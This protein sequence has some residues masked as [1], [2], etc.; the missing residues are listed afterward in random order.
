MSRRDRLAE[1]LAAVPVRGVQLAVVGLVLFV[2]V[3]SSPVLGAV[4]L[5]PETRDRLGDGT[6]EATL[7][8]EPATDLRIDRGR[9][10]T[11]VFYLRIPPAVV[12]VE[13]VTGR[14][15]VVY[16]VAV[17]GLDFERTAT[18]RVTEPGRVRVPVD[19]RALPLAAVA[20]DTYRAEVTVRIQSFETDRVVARRTAT[21]SVR[22]TTT[23]GGR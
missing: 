12:D 8:S 7:A 3:L 1:R 2:L 20:N 6:A 16:R 14:P 5:T 15:R 4:D 10:G 9:F 22:N 18:T 21:V 13:S 11:G 19:A 23:W 17:P